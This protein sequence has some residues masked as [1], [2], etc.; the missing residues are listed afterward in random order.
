V[1]DIP[2]EV[3]DCTGWLCTVATMADNNVCRFPR[4]PVLRSARSP[5]FRAPSPHGL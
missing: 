5:L 1:I 4:A 2:P 3:V